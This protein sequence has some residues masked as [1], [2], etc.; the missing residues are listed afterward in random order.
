MSRKYLPVNR[1]KPMFL[2]LDM[3]EWVPRD[4]FVWFLIDV[5]GQLDTSAV[6]AGTSPGKGR[7][8]YDPR[9][10]VTLVMY[11]MSCGERSS[12][13]IEDRTRVDAAFRIASGNQV[14]DH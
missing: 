9:M 3:Q 4:H 13:Q 14:P 5:A 10:L 6:E 8:G 2:P 1:E 7:P 12:R 11:A